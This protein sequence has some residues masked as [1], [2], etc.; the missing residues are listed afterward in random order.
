MAA[1]IGDARLLASD[2]PDGLAE[3]RDDAVEQLLHLRPLLDELFAELKFAFPPSLLAGMADPLLDL[4]RRDDGI[5]GR[6]MRPRR[7]SV[8]LL[9]DDAR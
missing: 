8:D 4:G 3:G 1:H 7:R 5:L 6:R 9:D 2:L